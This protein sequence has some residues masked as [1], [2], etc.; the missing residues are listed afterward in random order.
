MFTP[1]LKTFTATSVALTALLALGACN[2]KVEDTNVVPTPAP[3][4]T[5]SKDTPAAS[6]GMSTPTM[7]SPTTSMGS[8]APAGSTDSSGSTMSPTVP[9]PAPMP[10]ASGTGNR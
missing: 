8:G 10:D 7:S 3:M 4:T 9:V 1:K 2:K 6:S 5:Q